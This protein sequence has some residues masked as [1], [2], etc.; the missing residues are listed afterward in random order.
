MSDE[1]E[2]FRT[3]IAR[4]L[5]LHFDD[6]KLEGLAEVVRRR[7]IATG[8]GD[9][10]G[11]LAEAPASELAALAEE[12]TVGETYFFRNVEQ[13]LALAGV[14]LPERARARRS[15]RILSAGCSSGEEPYTLAIVAREA[16]AAP[17]HDVTVRA[18][19]VNPAAIAR[20]VRGRYTAWSMRATPEEAQARWFATDGKELVLDESVRRAVRFDERNLVDDDPELWA[21]GQYDVIFCR[22]VLMYFAPD[23]ARRVIARFERALAPGGYLFLGHAETLRGLSH[24]FHLCHT[25]GTFYYQRR[26]GSQRHDDVIPDAPVLTALVDTSSSWVEAIQGAADR[27][28]TLTE[29]VAVA[30]PAPRNAWDRGRAVELLREERF[31]EALATLP[32]EADRDPD[33]LLLRAVLL[34]HSGRLVEAEQTC[35]RLLSLDELHAGAHYVL[36][37]CREAEGDR[38]GAGDE[39]HVAIYL[40]PSFAMPR[41]HL[42]LLARRS[43]ERDVARRELGQALLLLDQEDS[44]RLLLFGGGFSREALIA[45]CRAELERT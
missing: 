38:K 34:T 36:A 28:R 42:G 43:G 7:V 14:V 40:D 8:R 11:W 10:A 2:R 4:R 19:D 24:A 16:V 18:I 20:A 13:F 9:Y 27:I 25:H 12:L 26:D 23:V 45:L 31:A 3:V 21:A 39:D 15:L 5:G 33:A 41:L 6:A 30:V 29:P 1:T 35:R 17:T 44:S 22:N 37:L 32:S